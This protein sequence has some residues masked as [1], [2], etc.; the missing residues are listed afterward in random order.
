[1]LFLCYITHA[2]IMCRTCFRRMGFYMAVILTI[3]VIMSL[4]VIA[5][6]FGDKMNLT[7]QP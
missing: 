3:S 1:M 6:V 4:R 2:H 5:V 7:H